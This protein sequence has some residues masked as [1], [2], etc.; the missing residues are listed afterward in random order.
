[1]RNMWG[2]LYNAV[3]SHARRTN[4]IHISSRLPHPYLSID[5]CVQVHFD[6]S[7]LDVT[8]LLCNERSPFSRYH[9]VQSRKPALLQTSFV[10]TNGLCTPEAFFI[11]EFT[12]RRPVTQINLQLA[13]TTS[14]THDAPIGGLGPISRVLFASHTDNP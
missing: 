6:F 2:D 1:M 7:K 3:S 14:A 5:N 4:V 11:S 9:W 12:C 13:I 8:N 10:I